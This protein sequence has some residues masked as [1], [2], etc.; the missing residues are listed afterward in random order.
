MVQKSTCNSLIF[1]S[2]RLKGRKPPA[3][4]MLVTSYLR[5]AAEKAVVIAPPRTFG[6]HTFRRTL[7]SV[8]VA[9]H[10]DPT[11]AQEVLRHQ[12][13]RT[14]LELCDGPPRVPGSDAVA[15]PERLREY[16][17]SL[18]YRT[19]PSLAAGYSIVPTTSFRQA[20][21]SGEPLDCPQRFLPVH[22]FGEVH[23]NFGDAEPV[24]QFD[25]RY[26]RYR[27]PDSGLYC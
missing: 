7:A 24:R 19:S 18:A 15:T 22:C 11:V 3:S 10:V 1:P 25:R 6:F 26:F 17:H 21:S 12:G 4:N 9:N 5:P 13:I 8:L 20:K 2:L 14:T 16:V 23:M 27:K